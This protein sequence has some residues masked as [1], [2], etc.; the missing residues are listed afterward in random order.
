MDWGY[1]RLD[2]SESNATGRTLG[3][4]EGFG[5]LDLS[6]SIPAGALLGALQALQPAR[7]G[8]R[9]L[10]PARASAATA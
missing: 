1:W 8:P 2:G 9:P 7:L 3:G 4:R 10:L 6:W 5:I